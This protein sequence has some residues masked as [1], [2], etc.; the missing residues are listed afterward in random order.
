[1]KLVKILTGCLTRYELKPYAKFL[2]TGKYINRMRD[3]TVFKVELFEI[4]H[5]LDNII[6]NNGGS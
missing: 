4:Q 2:T 3:I 1:M 5:F 6:Q